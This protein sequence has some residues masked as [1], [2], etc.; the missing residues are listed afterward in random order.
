MTLHVWLSSNLSAEVAEFIGKLIFVL[1]NKRGGV[2]VLQ[3]HDKIAYEHVLALNYATSTLCHDPL[4][5]YFVDRG[6]KSI[7]IF[8]QWEVLFFDK[9]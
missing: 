4:Q 3:L 6:M 8:S 2:S 5:W 7:F 1:V 9:L